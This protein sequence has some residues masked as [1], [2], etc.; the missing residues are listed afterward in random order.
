MCKYSAVIIEPREHKSLEFVLN[1]IL[2]NLSD[3]WGLIIFHGRKNKQFILDL[4]ENSL[5]IFK[6]RLNKFIELNVDNIPI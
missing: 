6:H 2:T 3:E 5:K 4:F 1:N